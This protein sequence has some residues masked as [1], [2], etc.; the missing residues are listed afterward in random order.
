MMFDGQEIEGACASLTVMVNEHPLVLPDESAAM[1][2]MVVT[3]LGK[4]LPE[5]GLHTTPDT[6]QLSK[7]EAE[8]MTA[9]AHCLG[10]V[11]LVML[12]GQ[13]MAGGSRSLTVIVKLQ[14]F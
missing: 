10:S 14:D 7:A 9:A 13:A 11:A 2:F 6:A 1:Q 8:K 5:A 12:A 3:P 4:T